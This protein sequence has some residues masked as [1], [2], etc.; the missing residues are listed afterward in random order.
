M[1]R[2]T[3]DPLMTMV[4]ITAMTVDRQALRPTGFRVF[5]IARAAVWIAGGVSAVA[6]PLLVFEHT[7]DPALVAALTAVEALPYLAVGLIAGALGD[8]YAPGRLA[9]LCCL[10]CALAGGSIP[11]TAALGVLSIG[12]V[13]AVA[14]VVNT[15]LVFFDAATFAAL[16]A[17]V[18]KEA[19]PQAFSTSTGVYSVIRM[20]IPGAGGV[21][22]ALITPTYALL[23]DTV[24]M[25]CAAALFARMAIP[26][27]TRTTPDASVLADIGAGLRFIARTPIVR[28]LTALGVGNAIAEGIVMGLLVVTV[29]EVHRGGTGGAVGLAYSMLAVGGLAGSLLLPRLTALPVRAVAVGG[30]LSAAAAVAGWVWAAT[31]WAGLA[32][33]AVY[34]CAA[35]VV[36]LNG[37]SVR[38]QRTP[39]ELQ[40]RVNTTARMLAWGGQPLGALGAGAVVGAW[41]IRATVC[42][43]IPILVVT[44]IAGLLVPMGPSAARRNPIP[45]EQRR[46]DEAAVTPTAGE[47][48]GRC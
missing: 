4:I 21:L 9:A 47:G 29:V 17:L 37:V 3:L 8:R 40:S 22:A 23:A 35:M 12:H 25:L 26:T 28:A 39:G 33:L 10:V 43:A 19:L 32:A 44:A 15:A 27:P 45:D 42:L 20:A 18:S 16:P 30:L 13:F 7:G 2:V 31:L 41:G 46:V 11:V 36:I 6:L 1:A 48:S 24:M 14:I 38:A 5:L 34:Q